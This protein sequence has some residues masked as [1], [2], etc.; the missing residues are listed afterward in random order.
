L[1]KKLE[2]ENADLIAMELEEERLA[3]DALARTHEIECLTA[4]SLTKK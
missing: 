1:T 4:E 3:A 2:K